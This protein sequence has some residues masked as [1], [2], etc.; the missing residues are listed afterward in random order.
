MLP[1]IAIIAGGSSSEFDIS[2]KSGNNVFA[3]IDTTLFKPWLV[4]MTGSNWQ[5]MQN[6]R[7]IAIVNKADFSFEVDGK[8]VKFDFAY[9][10]IHGTPGEDG[11]LQGYFELLKIPY[12]TCNVQVSALTFNK[13]HCSNF[14]KSFGVKMA[15]STRLVAG[16]KIDTQAIV[17]EF[18]LP[19]FVKP[20]A[21]GSSYGVTKIK[22]EE[23]LQNAIEKAWAESREAL[24]EEF[25]S[26]T[27]YT[28]GLA[29]L[30][31]ELVVFPVTEV[32]PKN[33]FFDVE[34][35][36]TPGAT[37]EITPARLPENLFGDC[38]QLTAKIY[39]WCGCEGIARVD[40]ILHNNEFYF[41]EVNTTPGMTATSFIPQQVAA[42]GKTLSEVLTVI[43]KDRLKD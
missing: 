10:T 5:V 23:E 12:S 32:L 22:A 17:E 42:M 3:A 39:D 40:Y 21:G 34:A 4:H 30:N 18:G 36:Y 43:I 11:I 25:I 15:R 24:V 41:L 2:V 38:Q 27:E 16:D 37:I 26:G 31:G 33:E 8:K 29:R 19:L 14:L 6:N 13:W 9:I 20:N 7:A 35:K 1:N 28:C